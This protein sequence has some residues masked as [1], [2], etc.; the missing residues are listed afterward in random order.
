M[1]SNNGLAATLPVTMTQRAAFPVLF[2]ETHHL[3]WL[4]QLIWWVTEPG[5]MKKFFLKDEVQTNVRKN[6]VFLKNL[7]IKIVQMV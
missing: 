4:A 3:I 7:H 1:L 2:Y 5:N 6:I